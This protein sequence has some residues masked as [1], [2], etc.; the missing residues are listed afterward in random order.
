MKRISD[1]KLDDFSDKGAENH[2]CMDNCS[3]INFNGKEIDKILRNKNNKN[4][5]N[6]SGI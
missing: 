4:F 6:S 5:S 2:I 3:P 1:R